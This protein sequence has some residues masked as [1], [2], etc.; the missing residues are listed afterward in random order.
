MDLAEGMMGGMMGASQEPM[1]Q[2]PRLDPA[3][4]RQLLLEHA[5]ALGLA[6]EVVRQLSDE[7]VVQIFQQV[8]EAIMQGPAAPGMEAYPQDG[9]MPVEQPSMGYGGYLYPEYAIGPQT[10]AIKSPDETLQEDRLRWARAAAEAKNDKMVQLMQGVADVASLIG[11]GAAAY[12]SGNTQ[13]L[14]SMIGKVGSHYGTG[15]HVPVEVEGQEMYETPLGEVGTFVGPSHE[16]G[17]VQAELPAGSKVY[18]RRVQEQGESMAQRKRTREI[19][20]QR[21]E[22]ELERR[23]ADPVAK[24]TLKRIQEINAEEDARDM[25]VQSLLHEATQQVQESFGLGGLVRRL[26]GNYTSKLPKPKFGLESPYDYQSG[27]EYVPELPEDRAR[28]HYRLHGA[29][30]N[31]ATKKA[32]MEGSP[33]VP[34]SPDSRFANRLA[35]ASNPALGGNG[36]RYMDA[37]QQQPGKSAM[38]L[39]QEDRRRRMREKSASE[40]AKEG[41]KSTPIG[42]GDVV[43]AIGNV[44][45]L[46][47]LQRN[48]AEYEA[49]QTPFKNQYAQYGSDAL[50]TIDAQKAFVQQQLDSQLRRLRLQSNASKERLRNTAGSV[51]TLR[52]LDI[53]NE[54]QYQEAVAQAHEQAQKQMQAIHQQEAAL[55]NDRDAKRM[56]GEDDRDLNQREQEAQHFKNR[57]RNIRSEGNVIGNIGSMI[58]NAQENHGRQGLQNRYSKYRVQASASTGDVAAVPIEE[59][60]RNQDELYSTAEKPAINAPSQNAPSRVG[61][62]VLVKDAAGN[63]LPADLDAHND[64]ERKKQ[65]ALRMEEREVALDSHR[66][67]TER[68]RAETERLRN[69][70]DKSAEAPDSGSATGMFPEPLEPGKSR[71]ESMDGEALAQRQEQ[72]AAHAKRITKKNYTLK[73][74]PQVVVEDFKHAME[75]T[76]EEGRIARYLVDEMGLPAGRKLSVE[77]M[78]FILK[79]INDLLERGPENTEG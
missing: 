18:S 63:P 20:L 66:A 71:L 33:L 46:N 7:Q 8:Q 37:V 53:A 59:V 16:E 40:R 49:S 2:P 58:N 41:V 52:A 10:I 5:E 14:A 11:T 39:A 3:E 42:V 69:Q 78:E 9:Q 57:D 72:L 56:A 50:S 12:Q 70:Q 79:C 21:A 31:A 25:E 64:R 28:L 75:S 24:K 55:L 54:E 73:E 27:D 19:R 61:P 74:D 30:Q 68:T 44:H 34:S 15:G 29:V 67:N 47:E 48:Q 22:K 13:G 32:F 35:I 45:A 1:A 51:N 17:G 65:E 77:Q 26:T 62:H 60:P 76:G 43:K 23:P 4:M 6:P 36:E 38:A